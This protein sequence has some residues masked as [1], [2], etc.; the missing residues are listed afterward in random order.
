MYPTSHSSDYLPPLY[1]CICNVVSYRLCWIIDLSFIFRHCSLEPCRYRYPCAAPNLARRP[2]ILPGARSL[3]VAA[4]RKPR[5]CK[6]LIS[7][8]HWLWESISWF[9]APSIIWYPGLLFF[10]KGLEPPMLQSRTVTHDETL[11][12]APHE[13]GCSWM[14]PM[15]TPH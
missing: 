3:T 4:L 8:L 13:R 14:K 11:R 10:T 12:K 2:K 9:L 7:L 1:L 5:E 6:R 15:N